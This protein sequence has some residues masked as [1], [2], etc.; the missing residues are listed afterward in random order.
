[1]FSSSMK[2][3]LSSAP[4][5][6]LEEVLEQIQCGLDMA[7][8]QVQKDSGTHWKVVKVQNEECRWMNHID[9]VLEDTFM[10]LRL[11]V[12]MKFNSGFQG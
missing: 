9:K 8:E 5:L 6:E 3:N 7:K 11:E 4:E 12:A 1:M 10:S 2:L